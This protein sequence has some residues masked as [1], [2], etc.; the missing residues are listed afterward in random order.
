M[1]R[2][3][4]GE[5]VRS[6]AAP[7]ARP[8]RGRRT[9]GGTWPRSP[10]AT[11]CPTEA[12]ACAAP[13]HNLDGACRPDEEWPPVARRRPMSRAPG[14]EERTETFARALRQVRRPT[15]RTADGILPH[16]EDRLASAL[17]GFRSSEAMN[18]VTDNLR[19]GP[20]CAPRQGPDHAFGLWIESHT[21]RHVFR[22]SSM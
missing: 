12:A 13:G 1:R 2:A 9:R 19:L 16:L 5:A 10:P 11:S 22:P 8:E 3:R 6:R 14:Q 4:R 20:S 21:G 17:L 15:L 7:T 18:G